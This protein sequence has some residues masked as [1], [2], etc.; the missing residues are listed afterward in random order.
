MS[1]ESIGMAIRN[2]T[3]GVAAKLRTPC[4]LAMFALTLSS[5]CADAAEF[6]VAPDG[7]D[8]NAG[9]QGA[10]FATLARARDAVRAL[11]QAGGLPDGGVTVWIRGGVYRFDTTMQLGPEDSGTKDAPIVYR[12]CVGRE[13]RFR[14][15]PA[16]RRNIVA[17]VEELSTLARLCPAAARQRAA[18][19]H[20]GRIRGEGLGEFR[21]AAQHRRTHDAVGADSQTWAIATST[22]FSTKGRYTPA[23]ERWATCPSTAWERRS[24]ACSPSS[25]R[26]PAIGKRN[27]NGFRKRRSRDICPTTGTAKTTGSRPFGTEPSNCSN[28]AATACWSREKIPRRLVVQ[29]S[30]CANWT[31][32]V[33]GISTRPSARLFLWPFEPITGGSESGLLVRPAVCGAVRRVPR[34][35]SRHHRPVHGVGRG[36]GGRQG[37]GTT[38]SWR[39]AHSVIP[40]VPGS[41]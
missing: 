20:R 6:Y 26:P 39:A 28:T 32:R 25:R 22:R 11:K 34:D 14:R 8:T 35:D 21:H 10:P 4:F 23:A 16:H 38:I 41:C 19:R 17:T 3:A 2:S 33:S 36:P 15:Q 30:A 9:T 24:E 40:R 1:A 18:S 13:R 31:S 7:K 12:A 37:W 27:S 5:I 29:E